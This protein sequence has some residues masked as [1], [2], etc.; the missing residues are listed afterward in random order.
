M[1]GGLDSL[2]TLLL[3]SSTSLNAI[4]K[5]QALTDQIMRRLACVRNQPHWTPSKLQYLTVD[6]IH[7]RLK[8][9]ASLITDYRNV[10]KTRL[11]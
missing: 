4:H 7:E 1:G 2:L 8:K 5:R 11:P 9:N 3:N 10:L 6:V